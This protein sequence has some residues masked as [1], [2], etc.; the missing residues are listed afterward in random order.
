MEFANESREFAAAASL[1]RT[2]TVA[3]RAA[4]IEQQIRHGGDQ[5]DTASRVHDRPKVRPKPLL[6]NNPLPFSERLELSPG[7]DSHTASQPHLVSSLREDPTQS[8][9]AIAPQTD[10]QS[11]AHSG[12]T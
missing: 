9:T 3:E 7:L 6:L 2:R 12:I 8:P 10:V 1:A 4:A 5:T 11:S